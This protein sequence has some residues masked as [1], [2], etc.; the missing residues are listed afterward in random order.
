MDQAEFK[1]MLL[2][3]CQGLE[4]I[5]QILGG[6]LD[7]IDDYK[8]AVSSGERKNP[9]NPDH[10]ANKAQLELLNKLQE[11][12]RFEPEAFAEELSL[13]LR[14][15][16]E[17]QGVL[18]SLFRA[19]N[20][21][22]RSLENKRDVEKIRQILRGED[23]PRKR[24]KTGLPVCDSKE[25]KRTERARPAA[26][27]TQKKTIVGIPAITGEKAV[28]PDPFEDMEATEMG[29]PVVYGSIEN[30]SAS[31]PESGAEPKPE[32]EPEPEPE[33][34]PKHE[35]E[36]K[37]IFDPYCCDWLSTFDAKEWLK[38]LPLRIQVALSMYYLDPEGSWTAD[39]LIDAFSQKSMN[40]FDDLTRSKLLLNFF[41]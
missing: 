9:K 13:I 12:L 3:S 7:L 41:K 25:K 26:P 2:Q 33:P 19:L 29:L 17:N 6:F 5:I 21:K 31:K 30:E 16:N 20:T 34:K 14:L 35:S 37:E 8:K 24:T 23:K 22:P 10:L 38:K 36:P 32:P 40:P 4:R 15:L 28:K 27:G 11:Q 18:T 1:S 39:S